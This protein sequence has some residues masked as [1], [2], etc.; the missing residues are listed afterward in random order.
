MR[1]FPLNFNRPLTTPFKVRRCTPA[2]GI[3]H[4]IANAQPG[5]PSAVCGDDR[6]DLQTM[7]RRLDRM[8]ASLE[9]RIKTRETILQVGTLELDLID[10]TARR[11]ERTI[12][13][14][15][16]EYEL[17]KYMMQH[18]GQLLARSTL[19]ADVWHYKFTPAT[20]RVDVH[21]SRLRQKVDRPNEVPMIHNVRGAGF[22]L[23]A[24]F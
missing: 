5:G 24:E 4:G 14:L 22:I 3:R 18:S 10:R 16:R 21:M 17:L 8:E 13:L 2:N 20:N 12:E 23:R 9:R 1:S 6:L 7:V 15:P 19:L 11:I